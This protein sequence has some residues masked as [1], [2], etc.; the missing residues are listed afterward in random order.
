MADAVKVDRRLVVVGAG[1]VGLAVALQL[2]RA[3]AQRVLVVDR[4]ETPGMGSTSRANGGVRAQWGTAINV[5]FSRFTIGALRDL[6]ERTGGVVGLK[7]VGYLFL[8]GTESGEAVLRENL[9]LQNSLGVQSRWLSPEAALA[10]APYVSPAGLRGG[11]FCPTDGLIDPH[12]VVCWPTQTQRSHP[13]L[14]R[15]S[16]R[17]PG[18]GRPADW[19]PV[20]VPGGRSHR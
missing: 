12:G 3:G 13:A 2:R 1:A 10:T 14:K 20:S 15:H 6:D 9:R 7:Q 8:T 18:S 11:R 5:E 4:L 17:V 16:P 19:Q